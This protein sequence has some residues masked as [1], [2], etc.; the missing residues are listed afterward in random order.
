MAAE[1][2]YREKRL[3]V[4]G[5]AGKRCISPKAPSTAI[6]VNRGVDIGPYTRPVQARTDKVP[7]PSAQTATVLLSLRI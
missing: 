7:E 5:I 2:L 6:C 3:S 4:S 1:T